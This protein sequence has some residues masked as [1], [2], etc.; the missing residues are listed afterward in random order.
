MIR[1]AY[2]VLLI[3]VFLCNTA[4]AQPEIFGIPANGLRPSIEIERG[5]NDWYLQLNF[6]AENNFSRNAWLKITNRVASRIRAWDTNGVEL[7][8]KDPDA[9]GVSTLPANTTVS[10]V[11]DGVE[12]SRRGL[13]WWRTNVKGATAGRSYPVTTFSLGSQFGVAFTNTV[14]LSVTP[15]IYKA[16]TNNGTV[17]LVEFPSIR[18]KLSKDGTVEKIE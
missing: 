16:D 14:I 15:L 4:F 5:N 1:T 13:Q 2:F 17:H 3:R 10:N 11:M 9:L 7:P 8:L 6:L 18:V 12:R